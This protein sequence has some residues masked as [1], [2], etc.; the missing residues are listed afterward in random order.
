MMRGVIL[1]LVMLGANSAAVAEAVDFAHE[2]LPIL[3]KH[4]AKCHTNGRYE[5]AISLDTRDAVLES[6]IAEVGA[7]ADSSLIQRVLEEDPE[8]R[9]PLEAPPLSAEEVNV[10]RRW[11][12]SGLIWQDGF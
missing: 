12:D 2:V 4:C 9:M 7:S 5:G 1:S 11:V 6:G 8:L 3:Q 10:L